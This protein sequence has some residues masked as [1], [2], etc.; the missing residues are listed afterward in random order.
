MSR[1]RSKWSRA[2][3]F[4]PIP[5]EEGTEIRDSEPPTPRGRLQ[6]QTDPR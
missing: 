2:R 5:D 3:C 6:L 1:F 4:R